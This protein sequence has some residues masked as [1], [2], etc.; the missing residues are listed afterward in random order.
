MDPYRTPDRQP[1]HELGHVVVGQAHAAVRRAPGDEVAAGRC[2]G[3]RRRRR[4]AIPTAASRRWCR[5]PTVRT[6]D[7]RPRCA[8]SR[9]RRSARPASASPGLPIPTGALHTTRPPRRSRARSAR[10]IDLQ[11]KSPRH[12]AGPRST[13]AAPNPSSRSAGAADAPGSTRGHP[14]RAARRS[15][16]YTSGRPS[17]VNPRSRATRAALGRRLTPGPAEALRVRPAAQR[18]LV[19]Q[20]LACRAR[21]PHHAD[22]TAPCWPPP[23]AASVPDDNHRHQHRTATPPASPPSF[24]RAKDE[25]SSSAT[26]RTATGDGAICR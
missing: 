19:R 20:P 18:T 22:A 7:R 14:S 11:A 21:R 10:A 1:A 15:A 4:P 24:R 17:S 23:P 6:A 9:A 13:R 3:C 16:R 2:H 26:G 12:A 25:D 5:S 8:A